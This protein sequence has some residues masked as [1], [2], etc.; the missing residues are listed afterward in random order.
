MLFGVSGSLTGLTWLFSLAD[1]A[2]P[3]DDLHFEDVVKVPGI[4]PSGHVVYGVLVFGMIAYLAY[5]YMKPGT[6]RTVL[7][8]TMISAAVL[9]GPSRVVELDH[10]P[11]DVVGSYL[12]AM[13]FLLILIWIDRH[14]TSQPG[15]RLFGLAVRARRVE[16]AA[17]K[18]LSSG[19]H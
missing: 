11:A 9:M 17:R 1:R 7:I 12:L 16:D 10:W 19:W 3:T 8:W 4:Y 6:R 5:R 2:R 13:P 15:G 14:P 18:R